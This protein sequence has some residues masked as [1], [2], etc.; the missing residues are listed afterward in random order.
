MGTLIKRG[1]AMMLCLCMISTSAFADGPI[2]VKKGDTV[3]ADGYFFTLDQEQKVRTDL[4][5]LKNLELQL[6]LKD[7]LLLN[8]KDQI[9]FH[10]QTSERYKDAWRTAED[11]LLG[12][13]KANQRNKFWYTT[14]GILLTVGAGLAVGAAN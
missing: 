1:L 3:P 12:A 14:L 11:D 7:E 9:Q 2:K 8:Y 10:L 6:E 13:I 5:K 4:V